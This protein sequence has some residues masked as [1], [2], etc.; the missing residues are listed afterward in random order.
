MSNEKQDVYT[1]VTNKIIADL[2]QGVRTWMK[3]WNAGSTAG[4]I[5]R[6]LRHNG[7]PYSGINIL[8][9]TNGCWN[10]SAIP[11]CR[12]KNTHGPRIPPKCRRSSKGG[13]ASR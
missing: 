7:V 6:P 2:E 5:V 4:R 12:L 1:R 9:L 10:S 3:P 11:V 13:T 8:M